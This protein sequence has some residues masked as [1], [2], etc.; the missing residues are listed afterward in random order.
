MSTQVQT[1]HEIHQLLS[2]LNLKLVIDSPKRDYRFEYSTSSSAQGD[3]EKKLFRTYKLIDLKRSTETP[4]PWDA[5]DLERQASLVANLIRYCD[6]RI[7]KKISGWKIT[8]PVCGHEMSGPIWQ[9][10]PRACRGENPKKCG[11]KLDPNSVIE[12]A[13]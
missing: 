12:L 1:R 13:G 5:Y 9:T 4:D 8:C 6:Y 7:T 10:I 2:D 11:A 3:K